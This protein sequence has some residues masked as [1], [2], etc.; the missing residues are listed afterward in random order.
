[1]G[2]WVGGWVGGVGEPGNGAMWLGEGLGKGSKLISF[3][4]L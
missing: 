2:G 3:H 4:S 1:M